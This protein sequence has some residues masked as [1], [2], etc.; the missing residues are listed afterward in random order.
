MD[1]NYYRYVWGAQPLVNLHRLTIQAATQT[2]Y[3]AL[4]VRPAIAGVCKTQ[5]NG[6]ITCLCN[7]QKINLQISNAAA[8]SNIEWRTLPADDAPY[9]INFDIEAGGKNVTEITC[10]VTRWP[11]RGL[12]PFAENHNWDIFLQA[13]K[14]YCEKDIFALKSILKKVG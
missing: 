11:S 3:K 5:G 1:L 2:V 4:A 8:Y 13:V 7:G 14:E 6:T 10:M 12:K 9:I